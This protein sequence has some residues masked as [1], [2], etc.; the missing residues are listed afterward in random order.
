[1]GENLFISKL[2]SNLKKDRRSKEYVKEENTDSLCTQEFPRVR[3][4]ASSIFLFL[5]PPVVPGMEHVH[6]DAEGTSPL[7]LL[8]PH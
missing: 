5:P 2:T 6:R 8:M 1:M 4:A 7:P 3:G